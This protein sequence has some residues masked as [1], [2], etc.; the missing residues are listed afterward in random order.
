MTILKQTLEQMPMIFSSN[1]FSIAAQKNGLDK[2]LINQG[3]IVT[4]LSRNCKR[5]SKRI[6]EKKPTNTA[7]TTPAENLA[8]AIKLVKSYGYKVMKQVNEWVEL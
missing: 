7:E 4:F 1:S 8:E 5:V 2:Y 3:I 6:W